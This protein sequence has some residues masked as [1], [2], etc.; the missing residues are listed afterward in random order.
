MR[1][2][3]ADALIDSLKVDQ[4]ECYGCPEPEWMDEIIE[5]LEHTPTVDGMI[6]RAELFNKLAVIHAPM[7]ANEYKA[8]VYAVINEMSTHKSPCD[9]CDIAELAKAFA[10]DYMHCVT[11][12]IVNEIRRN[13][14]GNQ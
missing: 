11:E 7:E 8:K 2:I 4:M 3:D 1:L 14:D 12:K 10:Q 9:G 5:I 13:K 6:N